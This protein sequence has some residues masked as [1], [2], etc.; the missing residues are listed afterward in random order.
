MVDILMD[1][2]DDTARRWASAKRLE[3]AIERTK[4][5]LQSQ[6]AEENPDLKEIWLLRLHR[7]E[8]NLRGICR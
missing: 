5:L 3:G 8:Q 2:D 1:V 6:K 4:R 7:Q